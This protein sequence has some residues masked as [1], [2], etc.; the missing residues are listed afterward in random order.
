MVSHLTEIGKDKNTGI[1][2]KTVPT[3]EH[4]SSEAR[5]FLQEPI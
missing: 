1:D 2:E 5:S 4:A 3:P